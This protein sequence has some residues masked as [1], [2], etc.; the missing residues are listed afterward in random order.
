MKMK[1]L[2]FFHQKRRDG[3]VRT[4][5][6]VEDER[7][8]ESFEP[9][10]PVED[11]RLLWWIDVRC[12]QK[13]WPAEPEEVRAWLMEN[14]QRIKGG[15]ET[16]AAELNAGIDKDWPAKHVVPGRAGAKIEVFCS[17]SRRVAGRE[18]QNELFKLARNW[19]TLIA[20]LPSRDLA[21]AC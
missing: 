12:A 13:T 8:L 21:D 6:E 19:Q 1:N 10:S 14:A 11:P 3:G 7:I 17:A 2:T 15:L 4:G 18:I 16:L 5:V 20:K 9:G